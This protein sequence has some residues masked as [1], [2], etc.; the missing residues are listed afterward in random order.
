[1]LFGELEKM[2]NLH[3]NIVVYNPFHW[4]WLSYFS[5]L[6]FQFQ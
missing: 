5:F 6:L 3:N 4:W 2:I 1:M